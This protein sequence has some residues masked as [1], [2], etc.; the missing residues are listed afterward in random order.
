MVTLDHGLQ[1]F[2]VVGVAFDAAG[3]L[4]HVR[5]ARADS[6]SERLRE[7]ALRFVVPT[8]SVEGQ[9]A[10]SLEQRPLGLYVPSAEGPAIKAAAPLRR[11]RNRTADPPSTGPKRMD[12]ATVTAMTCRIQAGRG[13]RAQPGGTNSM[14]RGC[15]SCEVPAGA[16]AHRLAVARTGHPRGSAVHEFRGGR[17]AWKRRSPIK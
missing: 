9:S 11:A 6:N 8:P 7:Q 5:R 4:D 3:L 12:D 2:A 10:Q 1:P 16:V 14:P 17:S 13:E 15:D